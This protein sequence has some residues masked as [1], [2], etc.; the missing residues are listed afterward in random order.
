MAPT[1]RLERGRTRPRADGGGVSRSRAESGS[2][3]ERVSR[4]VVAH[5]G[6]PY[7][8]SPTGTESS[9]QSITLAALRRYQATQMV[10]SRMLL[11]RRRQHRTAHDSSSSCS[12]TLGQLPRGTYTWSPPRAPAK[13]GRALVV[14]EASAADELP[15]RL[16]RRA[17]ARAIPTIRRCASRPRCLSGR[18]FTEIRSRRN[19]SYEVEA[20]FRRTGDRR[21]AAST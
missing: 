20:P 5:V 11:R 17:Q 15:A 19:L 21:T 2:A 9:L 13:L 18:F 16:L 4:T 8:F 6:H 7:G 1:H 10:T 3:R 12:N 14:R